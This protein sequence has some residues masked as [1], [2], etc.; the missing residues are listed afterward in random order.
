M[1]YV[2]SVHMFD[3]IDQV[4]VSAVV[5]DHQDISS[6]DTVE[7]FALSDIFAGVG[8]PDPRQWLLDALVG[9]IEAL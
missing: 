3:V 6:P 7:V 5:R 1:R 9:L 2:A 8:E 4:W